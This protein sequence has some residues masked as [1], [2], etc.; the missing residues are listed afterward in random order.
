MIVTLLTDFGTADTYVG[1]MKGRILKSA[2]GSVLVD[3]TH[4]VPFADLEVAA[5]MLRN[6]VDYFPP[7]T[8]HVC[9]VDPGVGGSRR[10]VV[11][12]WNGHFLVGPDNGVFTMFLDGSSEFREIAPRFLEARHGQTFHGRDLFAPAAAAL[13]AGVP[14]EEVGADIVFDPVRMNLSVPSV[15]DGVIT[16]RIWHQDHFGNL[17]TDIPVS[18]TEGCTR[19]TVGSMELSP[20]YETFSV[21]APGTPVAYRGSFG[22]LE[23]GVNQGSASKLFNNYSK[24]EVKVS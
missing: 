10:S 17:I 24:L 6:A 2:P 23:I 14:F 12:R 1:Q 21:V 13:A 15:T 5:R 22:Y 8:I 18:M 3:L 20:I 7:D 9:V 4:E 11:G 19:V 16:G